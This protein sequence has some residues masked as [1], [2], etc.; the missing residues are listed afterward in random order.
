MNMSQNLKKHSE[1]PMTD[2]TNSAAHDILE[3][4]QNTGDLTPQAI[5]TLQACI[6]RDWII[7]EVEAELLFKLNHTLVAAYE[8]KLWTNLFVESLTKL[9]LL[10]METPGEIGIQ[11]GNWL[12]RMLDLYAVGNTAQ[13]EMLKKLSKDATTIEGGFADRLRREA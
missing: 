10:D 7:D 5:E 8:Q 11:E 9:V 4:A 1:I 13:S 6:N 2:Q 3:S 12:D